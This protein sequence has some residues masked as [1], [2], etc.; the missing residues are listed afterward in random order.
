MDLHLSPQFLMLRQNE[1]HY[2]P[3]SKHS[4]NSWCS[5]VVLNLETKQ[6][7]YI[8]I[9]EPNKEETSVFS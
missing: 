6:I 3:T 2:C 9:W 1:D 8:M 5:S 7:D 4:Q